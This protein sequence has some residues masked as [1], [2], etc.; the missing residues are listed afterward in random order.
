MK[1]K[2][3]KVIVN[4][5]DCFFPNFYKFCANLNVQRLFQYLFFVNFNSFWWMNKYDK[6]W[7]HCI[8]VWHGVHCA[9]GMRRFVCR[10]LSARKFLFKK[11]LKQIR[12]Y[13]YISFVTVVS[14]AW[15]LIGKSQRWLFTTESKYW[16]SQS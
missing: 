13:S 1:T 8:R 5:S 7:N 14:L 2:K 12:S 4:F 6:F 9:M 15:Y 16:S 11:I 3:E 10:L